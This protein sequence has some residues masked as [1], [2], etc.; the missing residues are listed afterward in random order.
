MNNYCTKCACY[1]NRP[2][3]CNCFAPQGVGFLT[4]P[5]WPY[6]QPVPY[7][8][9]YFVLYIAPPITTPQDQTTT[10]KWGNN[11]E[12]GTSTG[13]GFVVGNTVNAADIKAPWSYTH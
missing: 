4:L 7:F 2:G 1:Y 8:V 10:I 12:S 13:T 11:V 3:D 9:P 6:V 5:H